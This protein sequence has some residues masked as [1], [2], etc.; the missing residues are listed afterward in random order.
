MGEDA[1]AELTVTI[2]NSSDNDHI[3]VKKQFILYKEQRA[4]WP[5]REEKENNISQ[6]T[7]REVGLEQYF[8]ENWNLRTMSEWN[9]EGL[10][11]LI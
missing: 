11:H 7:L 2:R 6:L 3:K 8:H 9:R 1:N 4:P 10:Q 5:N